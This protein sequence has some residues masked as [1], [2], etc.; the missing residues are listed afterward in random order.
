MLLEVKGNRKSPPSRPPGFQA[1]PLSLSV[2][3]FGCRGGL[4]YKFATTALNAAGES[5]QCQA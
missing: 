5:L 3:N 2:P 1:K 4:I